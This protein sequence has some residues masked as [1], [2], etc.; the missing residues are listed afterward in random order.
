ME[1][2]DL[3]EVILAQHVFLLLLHTLVHLLLIWVSKGRVRL[4]L[5]VEMGKWVDRS[6]IILLIHFEVT[7]LRTIVVVVDSHVSK[8][9]V[10]GLLHHGVGIY[11][12]VAE[13]EVEMVRALIKLG[14]HLICYLIG[15]ALVI[16]VLG[17]LATACPQ[18]INLYLLFPLR[19]LLKLIV[20]V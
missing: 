14:K 8:K 4:F 19:L 1:L 5:K 6:R 9:Y 17:A 15:K 10:F 2:K 13:S 18:H 7:V 11:Y 12:S 3:P 20:G 16:L